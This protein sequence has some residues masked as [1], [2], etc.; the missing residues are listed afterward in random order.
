MVCTGQ[1]KGIRTYSFQ[2]EGSSK[3]YEGF[4]LCIQRDKNPNDNHTQGVFCDIISISY[5]DIAGYVPSLEDEVRYHL[6]K[7]NGKQRCGYVLPL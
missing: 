5:K 4:S 6:Y 3:R 7:E 2:P 1:I